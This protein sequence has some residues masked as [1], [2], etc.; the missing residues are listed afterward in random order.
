LDELN[1]ATRGL[2]N[3]KRLRTRPSSDALSISGDIVL[4][5]AKRGVSAGE[6]I[7]LVLSRHLLA[8]EFRASAGGGQALTAYFL[9]D[10]YA[11]W[12]SQPESRIADILALNVEEREEGSP[13]VVISIVESKYVAADGLAKARRRLQGPAVGDARDVPRGA[14]R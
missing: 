1:L 5:A 3:S 14:L 7:G 2:P 12:L 10:D 11:S 8:E 13:R 4:R 9:L 6:M